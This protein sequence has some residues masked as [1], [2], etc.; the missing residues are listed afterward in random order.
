MSNE[1]TLYLLDGYALIYRAYFAFIRSPRMTSTG[2][3]TSAIFGFTNTVTDLLKNEQITHLAL[4]LDAEGPTKRAEEFEFYKAN[5]EEMPEELR[6]SIP[7]IKKI[8]EGFNIPILL[9]EGYEADDIIG[10]LSKDA[11]KQGFKVFMVTPDKDYGQLVSDNIFMYKPAGWGKPR[12][13]LG[14][15]E[16]LERWQIERVEQ[17]IDILG[18]MGDSSDNIPGIP[19]V[20]EKTAIKL[21]K[22]FDSIE[23][24]LKNTDQIKGKLK[25]KVETNQDK[26]IISKSLATIILDVPID[27]NFD[28]F[29][30]DEINKDA[31][32]DLFKE[33]EFKSIGQR[34]LGD[35]FAIN[36][37]DKAKV[38]AKAKKS[39][40]AAK[41]GQLDLFGT[42][43]ENAAQAELT[44]NI[45]PGKTIDNTDHAYHLVDTE[46]AQKDLL[47]TLMK[48]KAVCFDTETTS[49]NPNE[50]ELVGIAFGF[51]TGEAY[52]VPIPEDQEEAKKVVHRFEKFFSSD[53]IKKIGQNLKFDMLV[54][55]WYDIEVNGMIEDTM[56]Q[57]YLIEP[58]MRHNLSYLSESYLGYSPI[59]IETL[60]G[61]KG[62][63][64][65]SMRQIELEKVTEYAGEDADLTWQL[66]EHFAP[67]MKKH[68][69]TEL[70]EKVEAPLIK[71]LTDM[72]YEGVALD[73]EFLQKY[74]DE[75][76]KESGQIQKDIFKLADN[77][78]FNLDSPKQLGK[79]LFED[80]KIPYKG[81]K[82]KTGQY[83]TNE[84]TLQKLANDQPI[85]QKILE[86]RGLNKLLNTY[87]DALPKLVN[88][89]TDRIHSS[90]NQA[91]AS[92]GRLS[93]SNPNLQN[94]PIRTDRG[95][96]IREAFIPRDKDHVLLAADY[97][98]IE[99]R[100]IAEISGDEAMKNAFI[101]GIDIHAATAAKVFD[102]PL[103]EVDSEKRR[104]AKTVNFGIIYSISAFGLSQRLGIKRSEAAEL[105]E[106][107]FKE[108][109]NIK[110]YM[111][112]SVKK[113]Q[114]KGYA[115][116]ILGRRRYLPNIT[117][118]NHTVRSFA[119]R[120]AINMPIQGSAADMIK[121]AMI[122][123]HAAMKKAK[124]ESKMILQVHDELV[125]DARKDE[126][127]DLKK[128]VKKCMESAI[129]MEVPIVV[130]MG[131]GDNWLEA[132]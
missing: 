108:Y 110:K 41:T 98:Q 94:I 100:I 51:K 6:L 127:E 128:L 1:K 42:A 88:N 115:E 126:L 90:F 9:K 2:F 14:I 22:Q 26:A 109:P 84:E 57:H 80:M 112:D 27:Y 65:K 52:Y 36:A 125:F 30:L 34:V 4:V 82:T 91:I 73:I 8:A 39:K 129:K 61:K 10:T 45:Q 48:Q 19:G 132:H 58:D 89:R 122:E 118:K 117:S 79:V 18:L 49:L 102:I 46:K 105:I 11:E 23:N 97:S 31:L 70:Y 60:I 74:S 99:L 71:V 93:S 68:N 116:T 63:K 106:T 24:I 121:L 50:T 43:P 104:Y 20:G 29:K 120:I 92:T 76:T 69:F 5:R 124:M 38:K 13:I 44:A 75:L 111:E 62:K 33:L 54:L 32:S 101:N 55:K 81:A 72:E 56:I 86:Y 83:S 114:E 130:D 21:L 103:K 107:Y 40:K 119:E 15:P 87:V 85:I 123:V 7:Y 37:A 66:N 53:K 47:K 67:I 113:A 35:D 59:E 64:Q 3:N 16:I 96:K 95:K 77:D 28:D 25:E 17:V 131:T 78:E 12:Q